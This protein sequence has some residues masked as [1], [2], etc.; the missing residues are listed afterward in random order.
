M[1][2]Q[3]L[4][5]E[6]VLR[7]DQSCPLRVNYDLSDRALVRR[8]KYDHVDHNI[9]LQ[10]FSTKRE[11]IRRVT[12]VVVK[13]EAHV[14]TPPVQDF[15]FGSLRVVGVIES[16]PRIDT[17]QVIS[18]L[19]GMGLRPAEF[20]ELLTLGMKFPDLQKSHCII[21]LGTVGRIGGDY[22]E[23]GSPALWNEG[24][25]IWR[26]GGEQRRTLFLVGRR[27]SWKEGDCFAAVPK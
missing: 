5:P 14:P 4:E 12:L 10:H 20:H 26:D 15:E 27:Y 13:A 2:T 6:I 23:E 11:G 21:A 7:V 3:V 22:P 16:H 19:D 24:Y 25:G 17:R 18:R 8:G 1:N 9:P